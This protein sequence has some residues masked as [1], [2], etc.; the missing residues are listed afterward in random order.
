MQATTFLG[1]LST[2]MK[3]SQ[4][5]VQ[6]SGV[7]PTLFIMF[8]CDLKPID[9]LNYLMKYADDSTLICPE[10]YIVLV[11][12]EMAKSVRWSAA[13]KLVINLLKTKEMVFHE[14]NPR[15][16]IPPPPLSDDIE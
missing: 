3:I 2:S 15:L 16:F 1:K 6:G 7:V 9:S 11:E 10:K 4:S 12:G 8:A 13:N 14:S 5:I